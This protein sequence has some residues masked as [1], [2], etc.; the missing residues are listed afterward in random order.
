MVLHH[1][2]GVPRRVWMRE[3]LNGDEGVVECAQVVCLFTSV[4]A[5]YSS[6]LSD[7]MKAILKTESS[8]VHCIIEVVKNG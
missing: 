6:F 1:K 3:S 7:T 2:L 8:Q 5:V 4:N